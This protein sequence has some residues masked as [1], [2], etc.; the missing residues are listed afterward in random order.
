MVVLVSLCN[1][2]QSSVAAAPQVLAAWWLARPGGR[3]ALA[4]PGA[5]A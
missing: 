3:P 4:L 1:H 5:S 2:S